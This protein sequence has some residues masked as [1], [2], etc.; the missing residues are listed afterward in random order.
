MPAGAVRTSVASRAVVAEGASVGSAAG[1]L[2]VSAG[3]V[4]LRLVEVAAAAILGVPCA[5]GRLIQSPL[6][7]GRLIH[8]W[9]IRRTRLLAIVL[10]KIGL[11]V[12]KLRL[13]V[14]L[15]EVRRAAAVPGRIVEIVGAIIAVD[16]VAVNVVRVDVVAI[17]VV[18]VDVICVDIVA[19][20]VVVVGVAV[21][22][23]AVD[24]GVRIRDIDIA[25][26]GYRRVVPPA[27]P[28]VI[29]PSAASAPV[30]GR[31]D[32]DAEAE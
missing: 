13:I 5:G 17:D 14:F 11:V 22:V 8:P 31:A 1:L 26:V 20:D 21:I 7:G 10:P 28:R 9:L 27:S 16:V 6:I 12:S 24:E 3:R 23:V 19:V 18:T 2:S 25:V 30:D 29:A 15:I 32:R 4:A